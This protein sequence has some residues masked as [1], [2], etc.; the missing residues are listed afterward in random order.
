MDLLRFTE[1]TVTHRDVVVKFNEI[2]VICSV[3]CG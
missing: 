1:I 3:E 2:A